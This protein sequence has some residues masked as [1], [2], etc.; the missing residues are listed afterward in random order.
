[1]MEVVPQEWRFVFLG[2]AETMARVKSSRPVQ[3]YQEYGKL[4]I[5]TVDAWLQGWGGV[6]APLDELHSRLLTNTSFYD[7]E[8]PGVEWL[9]VFHSDSV[10]CAN[11]ERDLNEWLEYDWVGAPW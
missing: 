5:G 6:E 2:T 1:M 4:R 8:L 7:E 10:L 9:F 11:S 3:R